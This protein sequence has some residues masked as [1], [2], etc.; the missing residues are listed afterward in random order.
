VRSV[1]SYTVGLD[2]FRTIERAFGATNNDVVL[3]TVAGALRRF[4]LRRGLDGTSLGDVR[5]MVPVGR[6][7]KGDLATSG[8][9]VVLLL[10]PLWSHEEKPGERLHRISSSM[11]ELKHSRRASAGDLLVALGESTPFLLAGV[12]GL[13]LRARAFNVLVT[14][15]PGPTKPLGLLGARLTRIVPIVN[16]WP[17]Q[18]IGIAVTSYGGAMTFGVQVDQ[19]QIRDLDGFREDIAVA[20]DALFE[21]AHA[22]APK[23]AGLRSVV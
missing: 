4:V 1:A 18:A 12:L 13:A 22:A 7:A 19:A 16:L 23:E 6:H 14:N 20:F 3:A 11:H 2:A 17:H 9:R 21:A 10:A 15:V 5:A 8:N